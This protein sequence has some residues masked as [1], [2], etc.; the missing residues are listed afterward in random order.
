MP[1]PRTRE[2]LQRAEALASFL[3]LPMWSIPAAHLLLPLQPTRSKPCRPRPPAPWPL[4]ASFCAWFPPAGKSHS[5]FKSHLLLEA[6]LGAPAELEVPLC[7][8][9]PT[10]MQAQP[11]TLSCRHVFLH[12]SRQLPWAWQTHMPSAHLSGQLKLV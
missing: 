9:D 8:T 11:L 5:T 3:T 7:S 6:Y 2:S 1:Q 12:L 4:S 10:H